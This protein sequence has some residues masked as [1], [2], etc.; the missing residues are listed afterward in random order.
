MASILWNS[1]VLSFFFTLNGG[2]QVKWSISLPGECVA[3]DTMSGVCTRSRTV[4]CVKTLSG[5]IIPDYYCN[6]VSTKPPPFIKCDT[7]KCAK[8]C[9]VSMW[10]SWEPCDV[11]CLRKFS[12]RTRSLLWRDNDAV[13][14]PPLFEKSPC[15]KCAGNSNEFYLWEVGDWGK[16]RAFTMVQVYQQNINQSHVLPSGSDVCGP[17]LKIGKATR[18]VRCIDANGVEKEAKKCLNSKDKDGRITQRPDRSKVCELSC[19]CHVSAWSQWNGCPA[20]C[21]RTEESRTRGVLYPPRLGG[22][23]C[24]PLVETR[25]CTTKCPSYKWY[26]SPWGECEVSMNGTL[27]DNGFKDRVVFCVDSISAVKGNETVPVGDHLCDITAKP[28]SRQLC[29]RPCPRDCVVSAWGAWE[30]CSITCGGVGMKRRTRSIVK[31]A[32]QNGMDCPSLIQM[33]S[34]E[35]PPCIDWF[36]APFWGPCFPR[37]HCGPGNKFRFVY[38]HKLSEGWTAEKFC[39]QSKPMHIVNCTKPCPNDCVLSE[40]EE[41]GPCSK[42]CGSDGG[43]QTRKRTILA[44]PGFT[45][46]PCPSADKLTETQKCNVGKQCADEAVFMWKMSAWQPCKPSNIS[47]GPGAGIQVRQVHCGNDIKNFSNDTMCGNITKPSVTRMCDIPCP[48]D[49]VLSKWAHW[50]KCNA[51]C[52]LTGNQTSM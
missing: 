18:K 47:C 35:M 9:V 6:N 16:C 21:S 11:A 24:G 48:K 17:D 4:Q 40:W 33:S 31:T 23:G 20:D 36:V 29:E 39:T 51:T 1:I 32:S 3:S 44:Y 7:P 14:C 41:W 37:A 49:C 22:K 34:C 25:P 45:R 2:T 28:V 12:Y 8:R 15:S 5:Q 46:P 38:C 50:S 26:T 30:A 42:S 52:E 43:V 10:S 27:C 19:D 13:T